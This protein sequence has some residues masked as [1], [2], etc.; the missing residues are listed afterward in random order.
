MKVEPLDDR[1]DRGGFESGVDPLDRYL[2]LQASQDVRRRVASCFVLI[3]EEPTPLAF[4]T[5]AA[6]SVLLA[7]VP[8][9]VSKRLPRYPMIPATL[10][11]RLAVDHRHRGRRLG[12]HMLLDALARTLRSDIATFATIV[13]AKDEAAAAFYRAY[14]FRPLTTSDRRLFLPMAEVARLFA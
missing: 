2:R 12:E 1:H 4:Y 10:L 6:T 14:D 9:T 5:L 3:D 8:T 13:D 11:G 7:D